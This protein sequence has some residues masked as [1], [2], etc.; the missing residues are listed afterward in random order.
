M[1]EGFGVMRPVAAV[2]QQCRESEMRE[3][4]L[5]STTQLVPQFQR[6]CVVALRLLSITKQRCS[7]AEI[8]G[9]DSHSD[10][11]SGGGLESLEQRR[12]GVRIL[13]DDGAIEEAYQRR[14]RYGIVVELA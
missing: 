5:R 3:R 12:G 10:H 1:F 8:A 11:V 2:W 9:H 13:H 7:R 6:L 14:G 4:D